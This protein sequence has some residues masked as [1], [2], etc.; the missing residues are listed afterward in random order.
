MSE[1]Q[2]QIQVKTKASVSLYITLVKRARKF[3][4]SKTM[5]KFPWLVKLIAPLFAREYWVPTPH[6]L[7]LGLSIGMFF[8]FAMLI[9]PVQMLCSAIVCLFLRGNLP[10]SIGACWV[11]NPVTIPFLIYPMVWLGKYL[12]FLTGNLGEHAYKIPYVNIDVNY[13]HFV[14]GCVASGIILGCL[15]YP[16]FMIGWWIFGKKGERKRKA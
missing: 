3:L 13:A 7:A 6:R 8:A 9:L 4:R 5:R 10:I 11:S 2:T 1:T 12:E 15:S 14:V 16:L